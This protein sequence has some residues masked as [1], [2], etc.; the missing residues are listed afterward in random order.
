MLLPRF[1]EIISKIFPTNPLVGHEEALSKLNPD[2]IYVE[3]VRSALDVS[4]QS[5]VRLC[6][7]AVRQGLFERGV[8]VHCPDGVVGATA[9]DEAHLP[10]IVHCWQQ[11]GEEFEEVDLPTDTLRK[12]TFYRLN[13]KTASVLHR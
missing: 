3:N 1:L 7:T 8:E 6:E 13:D 10:P 12:T 9:V 5:A 4:Y 2:K 11:D